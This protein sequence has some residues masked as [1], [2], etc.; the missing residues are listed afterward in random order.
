MTQNLSGKR[1]S[2]FSLEIGLVHL[3]SGMSWVGERR[4]RQYQLININAGRVVLPAGLTQSLEIS[5]AV[6][7]KWLQSTMLDRVAPPISSA[8]C[9]LGAGL[10]P[11]C[12]W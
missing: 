7:G 2:H 10:T 12:K 4:E 6:V 3:G 11:F 8:C 9:F 5:V 1:A